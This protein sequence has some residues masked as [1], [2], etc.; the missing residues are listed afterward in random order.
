MG[1]KG[2]WENFI[3]YFFLFCFVEGNEKNQVWG[4]RRKMKEKL[5]KKKIEKEKMQYKKLIL[6]EKSANLFL[7]TKE[8]KESMESSEIVLVFISSLSMLHIVNNECSQ[9]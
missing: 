7:C 1:E 4:S 2:G 6:V 3:T 9:F 8:R 5:Q